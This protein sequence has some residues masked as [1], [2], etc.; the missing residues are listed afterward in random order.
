M[1]PSSKTLIF[2]LLLITIGLGWL[3]TTLGVAPGI[4]WVWTLSLAAMGLLAF[5]IAGCDKITIVVG[6]F[7]F[8]AS[9]LSVLRQTGRLRVDV[10]IP[11][12]VIVAGVLLLIARS[13]AGPIPKWVTEQSELSS[14]AKS[15]PK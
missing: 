6:P 13:P 7:F 14:S 8:I 5:F 15:P 1:K 10:E 11:V 4:D 3:L 12:L 9:V 2:P